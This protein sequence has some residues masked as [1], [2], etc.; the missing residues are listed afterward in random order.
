M[1]TCFDKFVLFCLDG[2]G[3]ISSR[4]IPSDLSAYFR[5]DAES[6]ADWLAPECAAGF[7][8]KFGEFSR[9]G[10]ESFKSAGKCASGECRV[11]LSILRAGSGSGFMGVASLCSGGEVPEDLRRILEYLP[12]PIFVKGVPPDGRYLWANSALCDLIGMSVDNVIGKTAAEVFGGDNAEIFAKADEEAAVS[13]KIVETDSGASLIGGDALYNTMR[14]IA[15]LP[16]GTNVVFGFCTD[17]TRRVQLGKEHVRMLADLKKYS[18]QEGVLNSCLKTLISDLEFPEIMKRVM[19]TIMEFT[20]ADY[21][22]VYRFNGDYSRNEVQFIWRKDGA[23]PLMREEYRYYNVRPEYGWFEGFRNGLPMVVEDLDKY[24]IDGETRAKL[25]AMNLKSMISVPIFIND[26][27]WG[28]TFIAFAGSIRAF[29]EFDVKLI[30]SVTSA[31]EIGI[32]KNDAFQNLKLSEREKGVIL[33]NINIPVLL[34]NARGEIIRINNA[35]AEFFGKSKE[36]IIAES[37]DKSVCAGGSF[38]VHCPVMEVMESLKPHSE[39]YKVM[40]KT[41]IISCEPIFSES[42][43]LLNIVESIVDTTMQ[44]KAKEDIQRAKE[45]AEASNRIKSEF[46]AT[47]SHEVR[48]PLNAIIGLSDLLRYDPT[49]SDDVTENARAINMSGHSLLTIINDVLELSKIEADKLNFDFG[50]VNFGDAVRQTAEIF[51]MQARQG[52]IDLEVAVRGETPDVK[53]SGSSLRKILLNLVGNAMKFTKEGSVIISCAVKPGKEP[54]TTDMSVAVSDTGC[55]I[56]KSD[57]EL[58]LDPFGKALEKN[59]STSALHGSGLGLSIVSRLVK[60]LG[61]EISL[62]SEVG[63]GSEFKVDFFGLESR[64]AQIPARNGKPSGL[65]QKKARV[66]VVDDIEMN[67]KVLTML[68]KKLGVNSEYMTSPLEA[69][70]RIKD[71]RIPSMILTDLWMPEMD[72]EKFVEELRKLDEG[73][74]I[75][76][77]AVTADTE[78]AENFSMS[79]FS[80]LLY[81]PVTADKLQKSL[82][83][84]HVN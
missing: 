44:T 1:N 12:C 38:V 30:Q 3:K 48:T 24:E 49:V 33:E 80:V 45:A 58:V 74:D 69:L 26:R 2:D 57:I 51:S 73:R 54:G 65:L 16:C 15:Q 35:T 47:M 50:W 84:A 9:G 68:L 81:K 72:G 60:K 77:I 70:Q 82:S 13:G 62:K 23:V 32:A 14:K 42:G 83:E 5:A 10:G 22:G 76:V 39:E 63:K 11:R 43:E 55:G 37:A 79:E 40:G 17:I 59:M 27:L 28:M 4:C 20:N 75:P 71:G 56:P 61:G 8:K 29:P 25:E 78:A 31:V 36:K 6:P 18:K 41:F 67:C 21:A 19:G 52:G 64:N 66:W 53:F 34:F 46:L 7:N